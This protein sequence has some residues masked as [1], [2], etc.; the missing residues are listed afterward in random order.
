M[1]ST[2]GGQSGRLFTVGHSNHEPEALL[3]LLRGA[4][5]TALADVRSSPFSRRL[6]QFNRPTLEAYLR[7]NGI[8]YV[9]LGGELGGRPA[10]PELYDAAGWA[11]YERVRAT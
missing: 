9:F 8:A 10:S 4:G 1:E 11:D 7:H 3:E 2:S 5:V 6:P